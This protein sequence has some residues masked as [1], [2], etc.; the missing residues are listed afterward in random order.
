[1]AYTSVHKKLPLKIQL[2]QVGGGAK[3]KI[4]KSGGQNLIFCTVEIDFLQKVG[5]AIAPLAPP[6]SPMPLLFNLLFDSFFI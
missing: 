6:P 4:L 2:K 5:G 1:M 3:P